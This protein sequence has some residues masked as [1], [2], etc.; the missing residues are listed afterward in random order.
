MSTQPAL[1]FDGNSLSINGKAIF[2]HSTP[3]VE[4]NGKRLL[5]TG[6]FDDGAC[7]WHFAELP[8]LVWL[9]KWNWRG[10]RLVVESKLVNNGGDAIRLGKLCWVNT[11]D[12]F[13]PSYAPHDVE[14]LETPYDGKAYY[15]QIKRL[16]DE[17]CWR[18]SANIAQ[19]SM[20]TTKE[21]LQIGFLTFLRTYNYVA[22]A[23]E[24]TVACDF[25]GW[26]LQPH[27]E[28]T[29]DIFTA[30]FGDNPMA[31]LEDWADIAAEIVKPQFNHKPAIGWLGWSWVSCLGSDSEGC[32]ELL[33]ENAKA[34]QKRL[35]GF[36]LEYT[37]VS[38]L[39]IPG[40]NPGDYLRWNTD[41]FPS[42]N[43]G[44]CDKLAEYGLKLGLWVGP[45]MLSN[46]L[47]K[48]VEEF[49]D[50]ILR[51]PDGEK[52]VYSP[53]WSHGDAGLNPAEK[54]PKIYALDPSHPKVRSFLR[55][56]FEQNRANGVRYYMLDFLEAG[57]GSIQ[58]HPYKDHFDHLKTAGPEVLA[59]SLAE[60]RQAVGPDTFL[61]TSTG[62]TIQM[63]G[64]ADAI[65]VGN[66]F[67][68]GRSIVKG[69]YF[70]PA[71][72][73]INGSFTAAASALGFASLSYY[74]H[75][76]LYQ[77]NCGNVLTVDKPLPLETA[78]IHA[79]IHAL[80]GSCTMLGDDIRYIGDDRL[81]IIKKTLPRGTEAAMPLDIF[82]CNEWPPRCFHLSV[83]DVAEPYKVVALYNFSAESRTETIPFEALGLPADATCVVWEFWH[84]AYMGCMSGNLSAVIPPES[85]R[86]F[87]LTPLLDRPQ[88]IGTDMHVLM[89]QIE[90]SNINYC[91]KTRTLE[92]TATRPVGEEGSVFIL[93]PQ[94][95]HVV[96]SGVCYTARNRN[97]T[98]GDLIV[99]IPLRFDAEK[100]TR[101]IH[102]APIDGEANVNLT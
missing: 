78:W 72:F 87:R 42:G 41:R 49:D 65:R 51:R 48:M 52:L 66:D 29:C 7:H 92:F 3:F 19:F 93:M 98:T 30:T 80:S 59:S 76:K 11:K 100:L 35:S 2:A 26:E 15:R 44:V 63:A 73:V 9:W 47:E 95:L 46:H 88:I 97:G 53:V 74:T 75:G 23:D 21:A 64:A 34:I 24:L 14:I 91:E 57:S 61:L 38:I 6:H 36:G 1:F 94:N 101:K 56:V 45:Y 102:F 89:G 20:A 4:T 62:P 39:N 16:D 18:C 40:G 17:G 99:R 86:V 96:D 77:N 12:Y 90:L 84:E 67:G 43:K 25:T 79:T 69:A 71:S 85:V 33:L 22:Y 81:S 8:Q 32:E 82:N 54:R 5:A 55:Q 27:S 31:Q 83:K 37:W 60:I 13:L 50:A 70:Y 58:R 10:Q 68:E 28:T